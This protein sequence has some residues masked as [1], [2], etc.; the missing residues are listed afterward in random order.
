MAR[1]RDYLETA[2]VAVVTVAAGLPFGFGMLLMQEYLIHRGVTWVD[3]VIS[4]G[5]GLG[6]GLTMAI[7]ARGQQKKMGGSGTARSVD[8]SIK[9]RTAPVEP[10]GDEWI[11]ALAHRER[12]AR[13]YRW[14][15]P[16]M[17]VPF[18]A[19]NAANAMWGLLPAWFS[20]AGMVVSVVLAGVYPV[21]AHRQLRAIDE[22]RNQMGRRES[23][24]SQRT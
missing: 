2:P 8:R 23:A 24:G 11:R 19:L 1:F 17:F 14:A 9:S 20:W 10:P 4:L 5:A 6:F 15:G 13:H 16:A 12:Q 18:A 7:F 22:V 3:V 21:W